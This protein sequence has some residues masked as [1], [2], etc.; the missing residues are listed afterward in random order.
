MAPTNCLGTQCGWI[1]SYGV[2]SSP[3]KAIRYKLFLTHQLIGHNFKRHMP[4]AEKKEATVHWAES[5]GSCLRSMADRYVRPPTW[6][7]TLEA[8]P[9]P[10]HKGPTSWRFLF[11]Q[12]HGFPITN[13]KRISLLSLVF[14]SQ[15]ACSPRWSIGQYDHSAEYIYPFFVPKGS[16]PSK[17]WRL[18]IFQRDC[19][20][21]TGGTNRH[22]FL[23]GG[24]LPT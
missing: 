5:L 19:T 3:T 15:A 6:P 7:D 9:R 14:I 11:R 2:C 21:H 18:D 17:Q 1:P 16:Q 10:P 4:G 12:E 20:S 23:C 8:P 22:Q 13:S 24:G